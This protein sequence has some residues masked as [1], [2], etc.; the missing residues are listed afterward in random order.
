VSSTEACSRFY[1]FLYQG[2]RSLQVQVGKWLGNEGIGLGFS[3]LQ[4]RG[5]V[6]ICSKVNQRYVEVLANGMRHI[7]SGGFSLELYV[8]ENDIRLSFQGMMD[9]LLRFGLNSRHL[10][11]QIAQLQTLV[12]SDDHVIFYD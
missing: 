12:C 1:F 4:K 10:I 8:H 6:R 2:Y 9:R 11:S 5:I 3:G 7:D